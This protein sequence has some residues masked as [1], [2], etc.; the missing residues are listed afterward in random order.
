ML[1]KTRNHSKKN[2]HTQNETKTNYKDVN[3]H[4]RYEARKKFTLVR[5]TKKL[6]LTSKYFLR[7]QDPKWLK[8]DCQGQPI[9]FSFVLDE[10]FD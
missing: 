4:R 5:E 9:V 8:N 7:W 2:T 10:G 1:T 6:I 3:N